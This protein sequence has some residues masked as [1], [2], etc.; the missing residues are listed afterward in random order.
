MSPREIKRKKEK[1]SMRKAMRKAIT[2][3]HWGIWSILIAAFL[4]FVLALAYGNIINLLACLASLVGLF[5]I[6]QKID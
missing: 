2:N 6:I 5:G 4:N 3:I 1:V